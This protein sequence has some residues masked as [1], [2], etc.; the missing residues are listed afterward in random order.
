M[1]LSMR[2]IPTISITAVT[3]IVMLASGFG[4]L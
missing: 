4:I 1:R 2:A 3:A